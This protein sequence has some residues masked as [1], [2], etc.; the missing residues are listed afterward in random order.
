MNLNVQIWLPFL[1]TKIV[2]IKINAKTILA[3]AILSFLFGCGGLRRFRLTSDLVLSQG[4]TWISNTN[5]FISHVLG[6]QVCTTAHGF[7]VLICLIYY[8]FSIIF[9]PLFCIFLVHFFEVFLLSY[10]VG[11]AWLGCKWWSGCGCLH[12]LRL[13]EKGLMHAQLPLTAAS[14][15]QQTCL[16]LHPDHKAFQQGVSSGHWEVNIGKDHF[17]AFICLS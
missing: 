16:S 10:A 15:E 3:S 9:H 2:C 7:S 6:L 12:I 17:L 5:V 8:L 13:C 11:V 4:Y 14:L 1:N